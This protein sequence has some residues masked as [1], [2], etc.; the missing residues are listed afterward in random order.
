MGSLLDEVDKIVVPSFPFN[1]Q[2]LKDRG[3][4]EGKG[5]GFA[6]KELEKEWLDKD[7]KLKPNEVVTIINK[8]KRS[9]ILNI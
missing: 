8:V 7:F 3:L 5:I 9:S 6:L 2:Y 4:T 1:G